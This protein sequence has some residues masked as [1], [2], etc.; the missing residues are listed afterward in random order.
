MCTRICMIYYVKERHVAR[1]ALA[2]VFP[3]DDSERVKMANRI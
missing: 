1:K 2:I 3:L